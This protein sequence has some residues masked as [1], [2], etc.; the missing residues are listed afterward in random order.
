VKNLYIA[1]DGGKKLSLGSPDIYK[2]KK[3]RLRSVDKNQPQVRITIGVTINEVD[4]KLHAF[5]KDNLI[6]SD[7]GFTFLDC[8][9]EKR[10]N[11]LFLKVKNQGRTV[12]ES[13]FSPIPR[14]IIL[15]YTFLSFFLIL[16]LGAIS[17]SLFLFDFSWL[18]S[19]IKASQQSEPVISSRESSEIK[20]DEKIVIMDDETN[21]TTSEVVSSSFNAEVDPVSTKTETVKIEEEKKPD[22]SSVDSRDLVLQFTPNSTVLSDVSVNSLENILAFLLE[23]PTVNVRIT[24]HCAIAGTEAGRKEISDQ[25]ADN[26]KQWLLQNGWE[27]AA[28]PLVKGEASNYPLTREPDDQDLNRRVEIHLSE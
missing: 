9:L 22:F 12:W 25:R 15:K 8:F 28:S 27:P 10:G 5:F 20:K 17:A 14:R 6:S 21:L 3:F 23:Y 16:L 19:N 4:Y 2:P 24:G 18:G 7:D 26:V 13:N 1:L 11:R